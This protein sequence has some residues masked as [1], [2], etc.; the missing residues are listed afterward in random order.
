MNRFNFEKALHTWRH[1][2]CTE[3]AISEEDADELEAHVRDHFDELV[4]DGLEPQK[5][6]TQ[7][8]HQLGDYSLIQKEYRNVYWKKARAE[9]RVL[10]ALRS[11]VATFR[12]Y[13]RV[14]IRYMRRQP[15]Y[16][17]I[18]VLGLALGLAGCLFIRCLFG[19][20]SPLIDFTKMRTEFTGL[21]KKQVREVQ[22]KQ[23]GT[24]CIS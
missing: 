14:S 19:M 16:T 23:Q 4:A 13:F 8:L 18:N 24:C 9:H 20:R 12:N 3:R 22:Q 17:L 10:A 2:L 6:F 15:V 5:A 21:F 7:A 11:S 1:F